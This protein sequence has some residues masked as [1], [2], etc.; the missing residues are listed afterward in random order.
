MKLVAGLGN[1]GDKYMFTRH[2]AGF[3][4]VDSIAL[5][6]NLNFRENSRLKCIMTNLRTPYEDY[7]LIKP[8]TYMNLSGEAVRAVMDYYKIAIDCV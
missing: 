6:S 2:N 3:M 8:T 4:L 1:I 7:L 5:N